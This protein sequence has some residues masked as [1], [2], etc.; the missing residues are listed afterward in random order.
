MLL[1]ARGPGARFVHRSGPS[2][3]LVTCELIDS[4]EKAIV[5]LRADRWFDLKYTHCTPREQALPLSI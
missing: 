1:S 4:P 2:S 3:L 5:L